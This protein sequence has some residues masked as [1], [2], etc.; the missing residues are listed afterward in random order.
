MVWT[1]SD[2]VKWYLT[3]VT[4]KVDNKSSKS[5]SLQVSSDLTNVLEKAIAKRGISGSLLFYPLSLVHFL[6]S[7]FIGNPSLAIYRYGL[8]PDLLRGWTFDV[9]P[10]LNI[11]A[12]SHDPPAS[13]P[14][15]PTKAQRPWPWAASS[16]CTHQRN[17]SSA[18]YLCMV[19]FL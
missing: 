7:Y 17:I 14:P 19:P 10:P 12:D 2:L 16:A 11:L 13:P 18:S 3:Q 5:N 6:V 8:F 1:D 15:R 9:Q 4:N